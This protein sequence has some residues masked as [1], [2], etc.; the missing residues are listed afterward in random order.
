MRCV[1]CVKVIHTSQ[2]PYCGF[3]HAA[4]QILF[5]AMPV[6]KELQQE[7]SE[8]V[9]PLISSLNS[10][11]QKYLEALVNVLEAARRKQ[12]SEKTTT[13][14]DGRF[15]IYDGKL[16]RGYRGSDANVIVPFY[17]TDIGQES[18]RGNTS[19]RTILLP[20]GLENIGSLGFAGCTELEAINLLQGL[21]VIGIGAFQGCRKLKQIQTPGSIQII[22]PCAFCG[23]ASLDSVVF[24]EGIVKLGMDIFRGCGSLQ[25]IYVPDSVQEII[26]PRARISQ[27][28]RIEASE[29]WIAAHRDFFR[30]N[31]V[32]IPIPSGVGACR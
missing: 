19:C 9:L 21:K 18:F 14:P 6:W 1:K 11:L 5:L 10:L 20:E 24:L 3:D 4:E 16:L 13:A 32:F 26:A 28:I 8:D 23:C 2:C 22:C 17:V 15:E 30:E 12:I 29:K 25:R 31:H 7:A 27:S